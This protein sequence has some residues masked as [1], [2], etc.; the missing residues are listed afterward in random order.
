MGEEFR[1]H[2]LAVLCLGFSSGL[3]FALSGST[4]QAWFASENT[5]ILTIGLLSLVTVPYIYK[6]LWAPILDRYMPPI[7]GRRRG[8]IIIMQ[9]GLAAVLLL[10]GLYGH[11]V[12]HPLTLAVLALMLAFFS[13]SQDISIDAYRTD[14]LKPSEWGLASAYYVTTYRLA[15]I[16]SGGLALIIADHYGWKLTYCFMALLVFL[17]TVV[18]LLSPEPA[19]L[20][21]PQSLKQAM[22][23]PLKEFAA[24][25][26]FK[27]TVSFLFFYKFGDAFTVS[28][29]SAFLI[30]YLH[31][32]LTVVGSVNKIIGLL[33][34][35]AGGLLG[36]LLFKRLGLFR[37]LLY[38]GIGQALCSFLFMAQAMAGKNMGLLVSTVFADNFLGGMSTVAFLAYITSLCNKK[39]SAAQ[40]ALFSAISSLP[41]VLIGPLAALTIKWVGWPG[42]FFISFFLSLPSF[43]LLWTARNSYD[44]LYENVRRI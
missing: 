42:F 34:T 12:S 38:F 17:M 14:I 33:S 41:R 40:F 1:P 39:M 43:W 18:T 11:P 28:L 19:M 8:W 9:F 31:Y 27:W 10:M 2:L 13:A 22:I 4:L 23:E 20:D 37:S 21:R 24:R 3:P 7:L 35:I 29:S 6:F 26:D 30:K 32:S 44:S 15:I 36:G 5:S 25:S 16:A